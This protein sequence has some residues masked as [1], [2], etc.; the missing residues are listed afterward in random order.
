MLSRETSTL[1]S[2]QPAHL[3]FAPDFTS[4]SCTPD[5]TPDA[6]TSLHTRLHTRSFCTIA[7]QQTCTPG[8]TPDFKPEVTTDIPP[9]VCMHQTY[10]QDF[11]HS[12][13]A[14]TAQQ[15][16]TA[17]N[18]HTNIFAH[19]ASTSYAHTRRSRHTWHHNFTPCFHTRLSH[20]TSHQNVH[21]IFAPDL[22][23]AIVHFARSRNLKIQLSRQTF[24]P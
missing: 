5:F 12:V 9:Q 20:H 14:D 11:T 13:H 10:T 18:V 23:P 15:T 17:A 3:T 6:C 1:T 16:F 8:F 2:H 24:P 22:H 7:S 4:D 21:N 19:L